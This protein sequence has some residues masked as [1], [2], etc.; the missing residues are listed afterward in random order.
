M[1]QLYNHPGTGRDNADHTP[2]MPVPAHNPPDDGPP[3]SSC[4]DIAVRRMVDIRQQVGVM[5][6]TRNRP[7]DRGL[8]TPA[9]DDRSCRWHREVVVP[10]DDA[11]PYK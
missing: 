7:T 9:T 4:V 8:V 11:L 3:H 2:A 10:G 1:P 5:E 6:F